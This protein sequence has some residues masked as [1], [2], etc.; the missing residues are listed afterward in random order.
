MLRCWLPLAFLFVGGVCPASAQDEP[1]QRA[2]S[3]IEL[4]AEL[5]RVLRDYEAAW[6]AGDENA[7]AA[8]FTEDGFVPT[9]GGW[10]RGRADI[11][12]VYENSSGPLRLRAHAYSIAESV[13]YIVG[14]YGYGASSGEL[15]GGKFLLALRK[16]RSGKWLIAADLDSSNRR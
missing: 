13:G 9:P 16:D 8:L 5:A 10:V 6:A 12:R 14:A 3:S 1:S 2:V 11:A 15:D 4:P 7:L